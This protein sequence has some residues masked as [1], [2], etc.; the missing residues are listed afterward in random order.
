MLN[1]N[2]EKTYLISERSEVIPESSFDFLP[3]RAEKSSKK[4]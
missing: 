4:N 3:T 2:W 1:N